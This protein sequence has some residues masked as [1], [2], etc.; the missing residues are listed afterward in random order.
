MKNLIMF[1]FLLISLSGMA[2]VPDYFSNNPE[3]RVSLWVG[4]FGSCK[5]VDEYVE[6]INGDTLIDGKVYDKMY[7]RGYRYEVWIGPPPIHDCDFNR[8]YYNS[9]AA[10]V[11]Q[12]GRKVYCL[13]TWFNEEL[14]LYDFDLNVGDT[15][16][17]TDYCFTWGDMP[18]VVAVDSMLVAG[19]YRKV[20]ETDY[21][22]FVGKYFYE[23]IG[24]GGGFLGNCSIFSEYPSYLHCY[25]VG[26]VTYLPEL[27]AECELNVGVPEIETESAAYAYPNPVHDFMVLD[28]EFPLKNMFLN[29]Y[30]A[31]GRKTEVRYTRIDQQKYLVDFS[32]MRSGVYLL[33]ITSDGRNQGQYKIV[34]R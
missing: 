24:Y 15:L 1:S 29:V 25:A 9:L 32:G 16:P 19:E 30:S 34:K 27:Y 21:E 4:A 14:L 11:R 5:Q 33:R 2:Q 10:Y 7:Q 23:G 17:L 22:S 6:Y 13:D 8:Y 26:G 12:E 28:T 31:T 18:V 3:W 20:F